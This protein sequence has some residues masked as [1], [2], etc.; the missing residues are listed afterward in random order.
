MINEDAPWKCAGPFHKLAAL[1]AN[2]RWLRGT[3]GALAAN[4]RGPFSHRPFL[5]RPDACVK[6]GSSGNYVLEVGGTHEPDVRC[7]TNVS[8]PTS[9]N[10]HI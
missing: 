1:P 9:T 4:F 7:T 8:T 6:R 3:L 10:L 5:Q 2:L